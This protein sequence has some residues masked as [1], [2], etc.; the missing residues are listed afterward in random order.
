MNFHEDIS[1][2]T[3]NIASEYEVERNKPMP[4][5]N[6]GLIQGNMIHFLN[7]Y[8]RKNYSI[9]SELSLELK[10]W[11]SVPDISILPKQKFDAQN[12]Q[13]RVYEAPLCAIEIISP[14]QSLNELTD[15]ATQYFE[16]GVKSCWLVM[17]PL[18][19]ICVFSSPT[20]YTYF[21]SEQILIDE[22]LGIELP[23]AEVFE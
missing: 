9:A 4:S 19:S 23:L 18:K 8:Y 3:T 6:H 2:V 10:N 22:I 16:H 5:L 12:D 15:K 21:R 14:S 20:E 1:T 7:V 17:L 13:I 11:P